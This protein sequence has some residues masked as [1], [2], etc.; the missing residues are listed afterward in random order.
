MGTITK[1]DTCM[2]I[3]SNFPSKLE[4]L[5]FVYKTYFLYKLEQLL[6]CDTSL[7]LS[8]TVG[9]YQGN[10]TCTFH[11]NNIMEEKVVTKSYCVQVLFSQGIMASTIAT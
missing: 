6:V 4:Q 11:L 1:N 3:I 8:S 7:S 2:I 9:S 5:L 10:Q